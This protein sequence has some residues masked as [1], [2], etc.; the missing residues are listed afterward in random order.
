[1]PND[2]GARAPASRECDGSLV[3]SVPVGFNEDLIAQFRANRGTIATGPFTG[4]DLLL[5]TTRGAKSGE[6]RTHPL[7]YI[8]DG[9]R[10]LIIASKG[11]AHTH[12]AWYHNVVANPEVEVEV[13]PE[14][15]RARAIPFAAGPERRRLYDLQAAVNPGFKEY[16]MKTKR[17]IPTILLERLAA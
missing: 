13:G 14:R 6:L 10:Y 17:V 8:K 12:P 4:R 2:R 5:L 11:G 3:R 1:M 9:E 7:A 16:E 15:F